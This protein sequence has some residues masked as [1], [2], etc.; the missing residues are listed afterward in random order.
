MDYKVK[1]L[2]GY[3][4]VVKIAAFP[5]LVAFEGH[6]LIFTVF[7]DRCFLLILAHKVLAFILNASPQNDHNG[8]VLNVESKGCFDHV[9]YCV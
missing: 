1:Q 7:G 6:Q 3:F 8:E 4:S 9:M 2:L 5:Y